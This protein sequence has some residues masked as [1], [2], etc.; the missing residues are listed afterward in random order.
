[1]TDTGPAR[2][3]PRRPRG[4]IDQV[5]TAAASADE[6]RARAERFRMRFGYVLLGAAAICLCCAAWLL[7]SAPAALLPA[8]TALAAAGW[9]AAR[10]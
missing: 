10:G 3:A 9:D 2:I 4:D 5:D 8:A 7:H 6:A 1:M